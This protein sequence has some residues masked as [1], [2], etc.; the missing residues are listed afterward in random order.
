MATLACTEEE[1]WRLLYNSIGGLNL[2]CDVKKRK[3]HV[4]VIVRN[5]EAFV[6]SVHAMNLSHTINNISETVRYGSFFC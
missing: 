1:D 3:A 5:P 4:G 2:E 6:H